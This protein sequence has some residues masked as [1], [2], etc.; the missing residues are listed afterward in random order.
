MLYYVD[1]LKAKNIE[2]FKD[3]SKYKNAMNIMLSWFFYHILI[4]EFNKVNS[5][6]NFRKYI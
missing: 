6:I 3:K 1:M 2:S 4:N 5:K